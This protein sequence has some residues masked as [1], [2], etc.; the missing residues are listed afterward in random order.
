MFLLF[1]LF[2]LFF[3]SASQ[4]YFCYVKEAISYKS[5]TVGLIVKIKIA[6]KFINANCVRLTRG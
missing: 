5:D 6:V 2:D 1:C 4:V 3:C